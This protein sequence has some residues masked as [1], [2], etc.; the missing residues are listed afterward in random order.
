MKRYYKAV[1]K[2]AI[3]FIVVCAAVY[4]LF[5]SP[6]PVESTKVSKETIVAEAMGTGTL[7]AHWEKYKKPE[8]LFDNIQIG[9]YHIYVNYIYI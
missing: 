2:L 7:D 1:I 5:F 6:L 4:Y 3:V 8:I 9:S